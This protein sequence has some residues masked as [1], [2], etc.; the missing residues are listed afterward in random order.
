MERTPEHIKNWKQHAQCV[1]QTSITNSYVYQFQMELGELRR[2]GEIESLCVRFRV[3]ENGGTFIAWII[4][5]NGPGYKNSPPPPPKK[6]CRNYL[7]SLSLSLS[8]SLSFSRLSAS[9]PFS[10]ILSLSFSLS[11]IFFSQISASPPS[12]SLILSLS[13]E[14]K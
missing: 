4:Q 12:L 8:L 9:P 10:L 5:G 1:C 3:W 6:I 11:L 13:V 14:S 2:M 7:F